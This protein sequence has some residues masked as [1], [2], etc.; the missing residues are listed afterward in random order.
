MALFKHGDPRPEGAGRK[1]GQLNRR[2]IEVRSVLEAAARE[3]GG[4][5]RLVAWIKEDPQNERLFWSSMYMKLL[6][7]QV[8]G[9]GERGELE[10]S[11]KL[12]R[13]ELQRKCEERGLPLFVFGIDVPT[14]EMQ[15]SDTGSN[16]SD[17]PS[18]DE[19]NADEPEGS[20]KR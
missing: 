19:L 16:G 7:V 8:M 5:A 6:P 14:L 2:T 3:L 4:V 1:P 17:A 18:L 10:L 13:E 11:V 20:L 12:S 9:S 15:A